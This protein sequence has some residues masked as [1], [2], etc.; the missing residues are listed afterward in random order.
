LFDPLGQSWS[1]GQRSNDQFD[2]ARN[3]D[4][5]FAFCYCADW[6]SNYRQ[7]RLWM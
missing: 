2:S 6:M 4:W 5:Y 7:A 3:V 1:R